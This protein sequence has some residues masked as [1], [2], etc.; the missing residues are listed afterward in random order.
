MGDARDELV[1]S[2]VPERVV[3]VLEVVEV[4]EQDGT[5]LAVAPGVRHLTRELADETAAVEQAGERVV[6]G[7][8]LEVAG[9]LLPLLDVLRLANAIERLAGAI[10]HERGSHEDPGDLTL[11]M[12]ASRLDLVAGDLPGYELCQERR[13]F[14]HVL[15]MAE[16]PE[17]ERL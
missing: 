15:R 16:S 14:L 4:E 2:L 7:E 11:G 12:Y 10:A 17:V 8:V 13:F 3:D 5:A 6:V 9:E 1:A